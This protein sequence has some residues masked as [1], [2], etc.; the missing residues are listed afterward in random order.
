MPPKKRDKP[1]ESPQKAAGVAKAASPHR[2]QLKKKLFTGE[3]PMDADDSD[4][5]ALRKQRA[6]KR[7]AAAAKE[8][9]KANN[10]SKGKRKRLARRRMRMRRQLW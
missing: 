9:A 7:A 8:V 6:A 1:E 2:D 3:K 4:A 10:K 5:A